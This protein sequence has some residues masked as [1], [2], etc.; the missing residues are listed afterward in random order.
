MLVSEDSIKSCLLGLSND[1]FHSVPGLPWQAASTGLDLG[2]SARSGVQYTLLRASTSASQ[3]VERRRQLARMRDRSRGES[4]CSKTAFRSASMQR[5][6]RRPVR[7]EAQ[8]QPV[9]T[10]PKSCL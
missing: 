1:Q 10:R 7:S 9:D 2:R 8:P 5:G 6:R 3:R 4:L